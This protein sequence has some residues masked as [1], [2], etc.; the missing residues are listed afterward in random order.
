M[1][2]KQCNCCLRSTLQV[3]VCVRVSSTVNIRSLENLHNYL[4]NYLPTFSAASFQDISNVKQDRLKKEKM[5]TAASNQTNV[6]DAVHLFL[7][8]VCC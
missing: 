8:F 7:S 5:N 3:R 1:K 6:V 4:H 2:R